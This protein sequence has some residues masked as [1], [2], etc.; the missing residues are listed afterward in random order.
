M[1]TP[2]PITPITAAD[3]LNTGIAMVQQLGLIAMISFGALVSAAVLLYRR[4]RS[5]S[6]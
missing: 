4:F 1:P 6:R 3:A 5:A 2:A